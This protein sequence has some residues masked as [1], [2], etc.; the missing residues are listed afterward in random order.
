MQLNHPSFRTYLLAISL[1][2]TLCLPLPLNLSMPLTLHQP[3]TFPLFL[4]LPFQLTPSHRLTT[5]LTLTEALAP[6]LTLL[7]TRALTQPLAVPPGQAPASTTRV[8]SIPPHQQHL[9]RVSW[10]MTAMDF[11]VLNPSPPIHI[12]RVTFLPARTASFLPPSVPSLIQNQ[13]CRWQRRYGENKGF[14]TS[15][16]RP[17]EYG[18]AAPA[19]CV[20]ARQHGLT[21][22]GLTGGET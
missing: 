11:L 12:S 3:P 15:Q 5:A 9:I 10:R 18:W 21:D 20:A 16:K 4:T 13:N 22:H 8:W 19:R 14:P 7:L 1:C 2:P 6:S 17:F